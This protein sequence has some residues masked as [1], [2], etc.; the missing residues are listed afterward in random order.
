MNWKLYYSFIRLPLLIRLFIFASL[1]IGFFGSTIH[2]VEPDRFPTIFDGIWWAIVTT[3]TIGYGD[4]VPSTI[5]GRL[6]AICLVILGAGFVSTYFITLTTTIFHKQNAIIRGTLEVK[7]KN[8]LIIVG[9]NERTK[10]IIDGIAKEKQ[11]KKIVLIDAT[12]TKSPFINNEQLFFIRGNASSDWVWKMA[13]VYEAKCALLTADPNKSEIEADM[14]TIISI[15]ALKG[16]A[17]QVYCIAEILTDD[18][19]M[20]A[21]RA[22]A[23]EIIQTN[24]LASKTMFETLTTI[25]V[26]D[27][28]LKG[29]Q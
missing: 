4:Y 1:F 8:H 26:I 12:L 24:G 11:K 29:N 22:G 5:K 18:Q 20:N 23:D 15:I 6:I 14:N 17:P 13:N 21:K 10:K 28:I 16:V 25:D 27:P 3:S 9:W 2:F 19:F 7:E